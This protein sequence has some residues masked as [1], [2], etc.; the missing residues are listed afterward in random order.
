MLKLKHGNQSIIYI[1]IYSKV[2]KNLT[3]VIC[4]PS[5]MIVP[6]VDEIEEPPEQ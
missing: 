3:W 1:Y 4:E 2:K 5:R 6:A